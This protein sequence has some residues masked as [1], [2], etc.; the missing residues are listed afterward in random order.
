MN[1]GFDAKR[2]FHNNTGL[3]NYSRTLVK[4]LA[5]HFPEHQYYLYN[6]KASRR[7]QKE[8]LANVHEILPTGFF[9]RKLSSLWRSRRVKKDLVRNGIDL[10]HGLSHE[11]P[12]GIQKTSIKSVVTI[13]D[14]IFE[15][16]PEQF[17]KVNVQIYRRKFRYAC[18][19]ADRVIAISEQTRQDIIER[20]G[21]D[22]AKIDICYQS[23][24][25]AFGTTVSNETKEQVRK[26]YNLPQEY[27]LYVGSII[28]RKN[29]LNICK[30]LK[31][32]EGT[33]NIPLVVIGGGRGYKEKV[34]QYITANGLQQQVIFLNDTPAAKND[35]A[36]QRPETFAAIY[37]MAIAMIYPSYFEGFGIPVLEALWSRLPVITSNV[38][39][40]PET[41]GN[42]AYYVNPDKPDEMANGMLKIYN[43]LD[44]R[45][46]MTQDGW[47]HAQNFTL[48]RCATSVMN[49]YQNVLHGRSI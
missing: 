10:Y 6:T 41:G 23:C 35:S 14:L 34:V 42:A 19:H 48:E 20:Y 31:Q 12:V 29:L 47:A 38:S 49:V 16:Y 11:I 18:E 36:F 21:T 17:G 44:L 43:N 8:A 40:M 33:L 46:K 28:E 39:C 1:I 9:D 25:P 15:R 5:L 26:A 7:I 45:D 3:G 27:F 24:H 13:H 30:A 37:Q 32:L 2:Y 4:G 22:P